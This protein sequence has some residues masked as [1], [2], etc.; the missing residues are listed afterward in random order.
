MQA[1]APGSSVLPQAGQAVGV[2]PD[3]AALSAACETDGRLT[4]G[5]ETDGV[6]AGRDGAAPAAAPT[7]AGAGAAAGA[8]NGCWHLTQRNCLPAEPSGRLIGVLQWGQLITC[9][10]V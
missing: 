10:M 3:F 9:G 7:R 4:D 8:V 5:D 1:M 6:E 2:P